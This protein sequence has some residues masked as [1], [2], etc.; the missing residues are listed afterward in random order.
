MGKKRERKTRTAKVILLT[1]SRN[2]VKCLTKK[3]RRQLQLK[4]QLRGRL[5]YLAMVVK[6][7]QDNRFN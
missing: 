7:G 2:G 6:L 1:K 4:I 3:F 5:V